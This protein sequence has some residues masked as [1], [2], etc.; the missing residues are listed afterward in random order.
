MHTGQAAGGLHPTVP[1]L[2]A[3][4]QQTTSNCEDDMTR[5]VVS[6]RPA[7]LACDSIEYCMEDQ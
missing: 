2:L 7:Q 5:D 3:Y 6:I 4:K 1:I